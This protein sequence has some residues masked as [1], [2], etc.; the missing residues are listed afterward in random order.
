MTFIA[1]ETK[2]K[3]L[4]SGLR[5]GKEALKASLDEQQLQSIALIPPRSMSPKERI[6][7]IL[8][9]EVEQ[10]YGIAAGD[11]VERK[12]VHIFDTMTDIDL[13]RWIHELISGKAAEAEWLSLV[14]C[15]TVHE[16][17]FDRDKEMLGILSSEILPRLIEQ[18]KQS[19]EFR[20]RIWSAGCSSGEECYNLAML[21]LL[22]MKSAGGARELE[23][24]SIQPDPEWDI[25][26]MGSDISSQMTRIAKNGAYSTTDMGPFRGMDPLLWRFFEDITDLDECVGGVRSLR[27]KSCVSDITRF[28]RLNLLEPLPDEMP[29]DLVVCRNVLIYFDIKKNIVQEH[30]CNSLVTGGTLI[31]GVTDVL[32]CTKSF[33]RHHRDG[34]FWYVKNLDRG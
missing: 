12:L 9:Q 34:N 24:G 3:Q 29:F 10:H 21:L 4:L 22:A 13:G 25:S 27:V 20:L 11:Q 1:P 19:G 5:L 15:L 14:E 32:S 2:I 26:V 30:L 6:I 7:H 31:L 28:R 16:T 17:Y 23:D 18:K 8:M 33:N